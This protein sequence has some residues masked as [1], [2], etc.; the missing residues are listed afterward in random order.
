VQ[1]LHLEG[2]GQAL[3][4]K[5]RE[6]AMGFCIER[7]N[8]EDDSSLRIDADIKEGHFQQKLLRGLPGRFFI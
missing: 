2:I 7:M 8:R 4:K 5:V 3:W 6:V 1:I